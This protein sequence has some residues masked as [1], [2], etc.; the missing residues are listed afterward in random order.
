MATH[1]DAVLMV[2]LWRWSTEMGGDE[3]AEVVLADDFDPEAA[4][5]RDP[6]V[7]KLLNIGESV[8]TLVKHGLL[9][10]DLVDDA[11]A[12]QLVWSR[13]GP[14]ARRERERLNEP[15]LFENFEALVAKAPQVV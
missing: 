13:I 15:R 2:Q 14:A 6:A 10:R 8:G 9:D 1:E 3:A 12:V 7:S 4:S 5:S 11:W